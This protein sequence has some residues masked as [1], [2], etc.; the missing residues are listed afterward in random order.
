MFRKKLQMFVAVMSVSSVG[1]G[2]T[3]EGHREH[4]NADQPS[5]AAQTPTQCVEFVFLRPRLRS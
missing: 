1:E 5:R 2:V 3:R 4:A